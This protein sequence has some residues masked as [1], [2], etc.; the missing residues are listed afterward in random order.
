[1][2]LGVSTLRGWDSVEPV[3][4]CHSDLS[5]FMARLRIHAE[6]ILKGRVDA[7]D[8]R[9]RPKAAIGDRVSFSS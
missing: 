6:A 9:I 4:T 8:V 3:Q 1:M 5:E 2:C 7:V